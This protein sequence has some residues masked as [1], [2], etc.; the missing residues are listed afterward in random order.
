MVKPVQLI[1]ETL[2]TTCTLYRTKFHHVVVV[3]QQWRRQAETT[4]PMSESEETWR[5]VTSFKS[6]DVSRCHFMV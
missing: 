2:K 5:L 4:S 6:V 1:G 3:A